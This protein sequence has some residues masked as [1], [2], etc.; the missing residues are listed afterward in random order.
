MAKHVTFRREGTRFFARID[1]G[2]EFLAGR[3]VTFQGGVGLDN[4][5]IIGNAVYDPKTFP[6]Q[7]LWPEFLA[8]TVA[9]E[10]QGALTTLNTYDRARFTFGCLQYAAHVPNGDFVR[11]FRGALALPEAADWF[12]DLSLGGGRVQ[13]EGLSGPVALEDNSST[14]GLMDYL[15]PSISEVEDAE[16]INAAKFIGWTVASAPFARSQMQFAFGF[17]RE[18]MKAYD[19]R[20]NLDGRPDTI[21]SAIFD[22]RHQGRGS[23]ADII[24]ALH[25]PDPLAA[26]LEVGPAFSDRGRR[27]GAYYEAKVAAG[28]FG[29]HAYDSAAADFRPAA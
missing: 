26:L 5:Q 1:G 24:N 19:R 10:G 12:P 17:A 4:L 2:T 6:D 22:I 7:G 11:W 16:V 29:R 3:R 25:D 13:H 23:S 18:Q 14:A 9:M 15:N 8:A 20:Y 27:L 28:V 21:C